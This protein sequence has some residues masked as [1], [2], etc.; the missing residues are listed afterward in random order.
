M[1]EA[2]L[3]RA[4]EIDWEI[5]NIKGI[6]V[7]LSAMSPVDMEDSL[8]RYWKCSHFH[9]PRSIQNEVVSRLHPAIVS[10]VESELA[11]LKEEAEK[12]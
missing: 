11:R 2:Q 4:A 3:K 12:L 7:G 9:L 5:R 6:L 10:I 1:T 8:F